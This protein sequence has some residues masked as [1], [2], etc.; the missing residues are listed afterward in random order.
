MTPK[1]KCDELFKQFLDIGLI[2]SSE[3]KQCALIAVDEIL[4][5]IPD[6]DIHNFRIDFWEEVKTEIKKL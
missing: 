2:V 5:D 1:E 4:K 3:A 6:N